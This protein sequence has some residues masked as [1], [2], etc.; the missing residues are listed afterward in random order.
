MAVGEPLDRRLGA[1]TDAALGLVEDASQRHGIARV[2]EH[3]DVRQ[4]V[5]D[6]LALVEPDSADDA[7][8]QA[9]PDEDLFEHSA[10][11]VGAIEDRDV[12]GGR[13]AGVAELVDLLGDELRLVALVVADIAD[14]LLAVALGRPQL[15]VLA[16]LVAADHR[17]GGRQDRLGRAVVLLEQ[18]RRG[19]GEVVLELED[20]A[21]V[22]AAERI[23]RLVGV[24]DD[25]QIGLGVGQLLDQLVL[26]VVGVLVLVDQD[27][28]EPPA[29]GLGDVGPRPGTG[30]PCS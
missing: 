1:V 5:L 30:G 6:L 27:V 29:I 19:V 12:L 23:D 2:D 3:P 20:V 13:V 7:V 4:R 28:P 15:L 24:T 8:G 11:R 9:D 18:D 14:D 22:G 16:A 26:R 21:D 25:Q 10:L 17:V